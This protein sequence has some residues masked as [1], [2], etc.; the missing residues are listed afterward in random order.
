MNPS[1]AIIPD[2]VAVVLQ[3]NT[4]PLDC[5]AIVHEPRERQS[6]LVPVKL[7]TGKRD[8]YKGIIMP[9]LDD[10]DGGVC[11]RVHQSAAEGHIWRGTFKLHQFDPCWVADPEYVL[12]ASKVWHAITR[13]DVSATDQQAP[14]IP[15]ETD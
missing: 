15:R 9:G 11:D 8:F 2:E 6:F 4:I 10:D 1:E 14:L 7:T 13:A 12:H 5:V 3:A